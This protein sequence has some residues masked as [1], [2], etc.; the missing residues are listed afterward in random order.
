MTT[1]AEPQVEQKISQ[2]AASGLE[3]AQTSE[4]AGP[5]T[6]K[7]RDRID[8]TLSRL[9]HTVERM[10]TALQR[11]VLGASVAGGLV[12]AAAGLWG[13]TEAA[14]GAAVGILAYRMLKRRRREKEALAAE[15][16]PPTTHA[17]PA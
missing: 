3:Q 1:S 14:L 12:A 8:R 7:R 6:T 16:P 15:Q 11:P 10:S 4:A 17:S 13:A 5:A 2:P 9:E